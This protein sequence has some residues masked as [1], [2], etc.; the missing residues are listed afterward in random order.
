MPFSDTLDDKDIHFE[1]WSQPTFILILGDH[2]WNKIVYKGRHSGW[3]SV[4][5]AMASDS[6][7]PRFQ[8]SHQ[9]TFVSDIY[10]FT[11]NC[12]EKMKMKKKWPGIAHYLENSFLSKLRL[13][14][15]SKTEDR[16][17]C[18]FLN[19]Q[20]LNKLLLFMKMKKKRPGIAH[21]LENSFLSKL[22]LANF[23]KTEDRSD[24]SFL[25]CQNYC[26]SWKW[27]KSGRELPII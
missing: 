15:F 4:G 2:C 27:R 21:Y 17:D 19:C 18:S 12:I 20:N 5:R 6:R 1:F 7:G 14:N 11:I 10:L 22:R 24:C 13:A 8:S 3:G 23:S 26:S 25:N 16:S 9:Q